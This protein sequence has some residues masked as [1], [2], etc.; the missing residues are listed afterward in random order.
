MSIDNVYMI[1]EQ[2]I[3]YMQRL[4]AAHEIVLSRKV[5]CRALAIQVAEELDPSVDLP[6][7][8]ETMTI[9]DLL[10]VMNHQHLL[11][12]LYALKLK[13]WL[14]LF[15][16]KDTLHLD[17]AFELPNQQVIAEDTLDDILAVAC[18]QDG[19]GEWMGQT[20]KDVEDNAEQPPTQKM[21]VIA[22]NTPDIPVFDDEELD[23]A[24]GENA[25]L[26]HL[27][28]EVLAAESSPKKRRSLFTSLRRK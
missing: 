24:F 7:H 5:L 19:F 6:P 21:D 22:V 18:F 15:A 25:E 16:H 14:V 20:I 28:S 17:G 10:D 8:F 9:P 4:C 13:L 2:P 12:D 26:A 23:L 1:A 27:V 11:I 3:A